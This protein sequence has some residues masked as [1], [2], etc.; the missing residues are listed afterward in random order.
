MKQKPIIS[1]LTYFFI[2]LFLGFVLFPIF[3]MISTSLKP[4]EEIRSTNPSFIP[5]RVTFQHFFYVLTRYEFIRYLVNS[6]FVATV[7]A[8]FG[9]VISSFAGYAISRFSRIQGINVIS[10]LVLISQI[11]PAVLLLV[12]LYIIMM[13]LH[14][15]N[16]Y[17]SMILSYTTFSIPFCT[18]MLKAYFD[19]IAV[20]LE[21]AA[22]IDGCTRVGALFKIIFPLAAPGVAATGIF[23]FMLA[24]SEFMFAYTFVDT[25]RFR[26]LPVGLSLFRGL[27]G[28]SWHFMMAASILA[29]VPAVVAFSFL[30]KYLVQGLQAGAVKG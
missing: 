17:W 1:V 12:P 26:T 2:F 25:Y 19:S 28:T 10:I 24:W 18:W 21:E 8:V 22:M 14:L 16:T 29:L 7:T 15:L 4:V 30:Q 9:I 20:E 13:K 23:C 6:L 5:S 27:W 11:I 3:W